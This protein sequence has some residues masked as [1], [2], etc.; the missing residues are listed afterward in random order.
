ME[1]DT[2]RLMLRAWI[3]AVL[4][5][6]LVRV[7]AEERLE[8]VSTQLDQLQHDF[9]VQLIFDVGSW[10]VEIFGFGEMN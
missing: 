2:N 4:H 7:P 8:F 1:I 3:D 9:G 6:A 5:H 10:S